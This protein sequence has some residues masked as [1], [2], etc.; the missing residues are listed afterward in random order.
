MNTI[1][2]ENIYYL[3]CYAWNKL[4]EKDIVSLEKIESNNILELLSRVL[5]SGTS[6]LFKR[7]LDR[8]YIDFQE[9][10][11]SIKG[12]IDFGVTIKKDLLRNA[13]ISCTYDELSYNILHNQII[14]STF[15]I[16][17]KCKDIDK[18]LHLNLLSIY[19][20]FSDIDNIKITKKVFK[21]VRL[22]KN[23][24]YYSF[25]LN[26]CEL[27]NDKMLITD[28]KG[29][30]K[31]K[32]FTRDERAMN[33]LFES[34]VRNFYKK[35]LKGKYSVG[36]IKIPWNAMPLDKDSEGFLPEM[37]TDIFLE[38]KSEKIIIDTK[39]YKEALQTYFNKKTIHS[40][41]LYQIFSY[42]KNFEILDSNN[43]DCKGMLL[44]P[45]VDQE[46]S[47]SYKIDNHKVMVNT[48][49]LNQNWKGIHNSLI[50]LLK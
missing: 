43:S 7:G 5:I 42:L 9:E 12:K 23:N 32:D 35:E 48:I 20:K 8:A 40:N 11:R 38:S 41:N 46:I 29:N 15:K 6:F 17:L 31:F 22:N 14:K 47:L 28:K 24:S 1:P 21:Q 4:E 36:C 39:Y 10:S 27:I 2:I 3:L 19:R 13:K 37:R 50:N 34:F 44:Y 25:L 33:R 16:L 26:I 30:T 45:T 49:N 18:E